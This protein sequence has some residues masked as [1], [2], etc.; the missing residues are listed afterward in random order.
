[1]PI[2]HPLRLATPADAALIAHHRGHMFEDIASLSPPD[3]AT[4]IAATQ[5]WIAE[6]LTTGEYLGWLIEDAQQGTVVAGAGLHLRSQ[7][8]VPGTLRS[9]QWAHIA[10]VYTEPTHRRLGLARRL[11]TEIIAWCTANAVDRVTLTASPDGLPLYRSLGFHP[12]DDL[13]L[14]LENS[15]SA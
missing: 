7:G 15:P 10:N 2:V 8:P 6:L 11:L 5:P 9:G 13:R 1:M 3:T 14:R 12:T 4:L